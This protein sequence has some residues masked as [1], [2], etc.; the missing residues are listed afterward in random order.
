LDLCDQT[1]QP[2]GYDRNGN[3][4]C[5]GQCFGGGRDLVQQLAAR[6]WSSVLRRPHQDS[7]P[8]S[9]CWPKRESTVS[10]A[11]L[12][13]RAQGCM[14][15]QLAGDSL[16][17]LVEFEN[18]THIRRTHPGGVRLLVDGGHWQTIAG[19]PTDDSEMALALARSIV[20]HGGYDPEEAARAYAWWY[21]SG[22]FDIGMATTTAVSAAAAALRAGQSAAEAARTAAGR[23]TQANGALMRVSPLGI[24]GGAAGE[25]KA[26]Q[27]AQQDA[28]LTHPNPVCQ[29]ANTVFAEAL[30]FAIRTGS[31]PQQVYGFALELANST[32]SLQSVTE[33]IIKA[34][35][36]P[37]DDYSKHKG[38]VLIALQNAFW[39]LL[40]AEGLEEGVVSTVASGGDT[41]TNA[42]I[43][44][45]LL[46]AVH[47]RSAIPTQWLDRILSCRPMSG[48]AGITHPRPE[49]FWP[50]DS[51]WLAERL[52]WLGG[53]TKA[54]TVGTASPTGIVGRG[55]GTADERKKGATAQTGAAEGRE[56]LTRYWDGVIRAK[57]GKPITEKGRI[58][59]A[60]ESADWAGFL[61]LL[62]DNPKLVN[63]VLSR[64]RS[65]CHVLHQ[66]A[67][68]HAP[69]DLLDE[70]IGLG[71]FR[72]ITDSSGRRPLDIVTKEA[73]DDL[74]T[75]LQ[76]CIEHP[77]DPER[78]A[79][80]Q[81]LFHGLIR[82]VMLVFKVSL[83]M[84][85]PQLSVLTEIKDLAVWFPIPGMYGGFHF[86]LDN[87][88]DGA[89][90]IAESS[91]RVSGEVMCH[92]ITPI[93]VVLVEEDSTIFIEPISSGTLESL[94]RGDESVI[95]S[96]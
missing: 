94:M 91:C 23:E 95:S 90:L 85:L 37:P 19:Q 96:G 15:G 61:R 86:W 62:H 48:V 87:A 41:D 18:A 44:G 84:R 54:G 79:R 51:L 33:A 49:A 24:L 42:A 89:V 30:A 57:H 22:P 70:L 66:A 9:L 31:N 67:R 64:R 59:A 2:I 7:V 58:Q 77:V 11:G 5:G 78:L 93:E 52:V 82:S 76:P 32:E 75:S 65:W 17:G 55:D 8:Y 88:D 73:S 50:V 3:S 74:F 43:T 83:Q 71:A 25:G 63:A 34:A 12:L 69:V 38:W 6:E 35:S 81:E 1:G 68:C 53:T 47:G 80:I 26:A 72:T 4:T 27:W 10:N 39:Q 46:G 13:S 20:N 45:A 16:G 60:L 36:M 92:R 40:H 14:L 28:L 21:E 29:A 56:R